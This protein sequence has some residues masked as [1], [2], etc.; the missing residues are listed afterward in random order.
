MTIPA[1]KKKFMRGRS[2]SFCERETY[3]KKKVTQDCSL[4]SVVLIALGLSF[5]D[6]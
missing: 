4:K 6:K 2:L 1:P 3:L 5:Y